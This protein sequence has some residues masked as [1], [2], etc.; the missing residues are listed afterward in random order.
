MARSTVFTTNR[1]QAVRLPKPVAFP[2]GVD[3]VDIVSIGQS[4]VLTPIGKR[5][6]D[7]FLNGP[8]ASADFMTK[9]KRLKPEDREP[10]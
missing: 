7:F 4:R 2:E 5:W 1:T 3:H 6:D 8:R 10:L 9:R